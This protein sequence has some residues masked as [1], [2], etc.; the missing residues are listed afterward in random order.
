MENKCK[1]CEFYLAAK[2]KKPTIEQCKEYAVSIGWVNFD[3][4]GF[5]WKQESLGWT[6]PNGRPYKNYKGIIQTWYRASVRRGDIKPDEKTFKQK[7]E[8]NKS[9]H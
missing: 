5:F 7:F 9:G 6:H 8:E 1:Q 3:A 2:F 4:E